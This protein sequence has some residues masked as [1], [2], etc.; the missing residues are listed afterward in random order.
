M[1]EGVLGLMKVLSVDIALYNVESEYKARAEGFLED[2]RVLDAK[3]TKFE[4]SFTNYKV[5]YTIQVGLVTGCA[6]KDK[7]IEAREKGAEA[8]NKSIEDLRGK[9]VTLEVDKKVLESSLNFM[10]V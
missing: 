9:L 8:S 7:K 6:Q 10:D 4:N 3:V 1:T 2:K 5:K